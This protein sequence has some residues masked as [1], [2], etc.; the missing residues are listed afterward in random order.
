MNNNSKLDAL[1]IFPPLTL[2]ERYGERKVG[3]VGGFLPPLGISYIA[4][5]L[6][7][8]GYKVDVIDALS[9]HMTEDDIIKA[10]KAGD[11]KVI[12]LSSLTPMFNRAVQISK[13]IQECF[14]EKLIIIGGQ[15]ASIMTRDVL[16]ENECFDIVVCGEGENTVLE[17]MNSFSAGNYDKREFLNNVDRLSKIKGIAFHKGNTIVQNPPCDHIKDLDTLPF[18]AW[19]L[20][21]ME[22]YIPLPNQYMRQ[23]VVHM[24]TTRGCPFVCSFCSC[25]AVFGRTIRSHSPQ[26]VIEA[27]KHV[28]KKYGAKEIMFWDDTI[29][30]NKKWIKDVCRK[31]ID[32]KLDITWSC[33][34][35]VDTIDREMVH[36]MK[37]A[38]CW[39]LLF[40]FEAGTQELLDNIKK[41]IKLEQCKK[42]MKWTK[43]EGIEVRASFMLALPG[44]TPEM[45]EETIK[46]AIELDPDYAQFLITTPYPGTSL[47]DNIEKYGTVS[48]DYSK[49]SFWSPV[50]VPYGYKDRNE[51]ARMQKR[52]MRKFYF[53]PK[54]IYGKFGKIRSLEDIKRYYKGLRLA[55][56]V[57]R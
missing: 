57:G 29:T 42:V 28:K 9:S 12:G 55:I 56:G 19:D 50:F 2:Y 45:A 31:M 14:P 51:V 25:N 34:S 3:N 5:Y 22:N 39:N 24:I 40:G 18:P 20:L 10:I 41:G 8:S 49:Y 30:V 53:R 6:R 4:S 17:L 52:A 1:F 37:K 35:R 11:P 36:L 13:K 27:I 46:F 15:H 47:H 16:S 21:P 38:G 48:K 26:R 7:Q 23:P 32:G 33:L 44:E 54:F 43:E